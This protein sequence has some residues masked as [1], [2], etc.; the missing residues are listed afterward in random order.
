MKEKSKGTTAKK[1]T[2]KLNDSPK[3]L[4]GM[5]FQEYLDDVTLVRTKP[6]IPEKRE[7]NKTDIPERKKKEEGGKKE[8]EATQENTDKGEK[9]EQNTYQEVEGSTENIYETITFD[10]DKTDTDTNS[11][12]SEEWLKKEPEPPDQKKLHDR[13]LE[14]L[15]D[16]FLIKTEQH[17]L[18][19]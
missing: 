6:Q 17:S 3:A 13:M 19:K 5:V 7:T 4:H 2:E 12:P 14:E 9:T 18:H 15:L 16:H 11:E 10:E 1:S 8:E